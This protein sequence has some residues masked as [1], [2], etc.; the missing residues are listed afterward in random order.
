M[1]NTAY[2]ERLN[3]TCRAHPAPLVRRTRAAARRAATVE[4][5]MWLVGTGD[6]F[7]WPQDSLRR[8]RRPSDPPGGNWV[9]RTPA[10]AAGLTAHCWSLHQLLTYQVPPP[11]VKRRGRRPRWLVQAAVAPAA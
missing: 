8:R 4:A 2:V 7:C 6:T 1:L 5:G 3:A 11:P 9:A 10:Q